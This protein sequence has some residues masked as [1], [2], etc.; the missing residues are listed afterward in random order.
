M[1][2]SCYGSASPSRVTHSGSL[3]FAFIGLPILALLGFFWLGIPDSHAWQLVLSLIAGALLILAFLWLISSVVR[4]LRNT[5][6]PCAHWLGAVLVAVWLFIKWI[7]ITAASHLDDN[8]MARSG[9]LNSKLSAS[10][11]ATLTFDRLDAW[12]HDLVLLLLWIVIPALLTPFF[13]ETVSCGLGGGVWRV[14]ARVLR[15]WQA[16]ARHHFLRTSLMYWLTGKLTGWRPSH[17]V[18]GELISLA[19]RLCLCYIADFLLIT[20]LLAIDSHLLARE[21]GPPEPRCGAN[22]GPRLSRIAQSACSPKPRPH[23]V[24][25]ATA[26]NLSRAVMRRRSAHSS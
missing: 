3:L 2:H 25:L 11:R 23:D 1:T 13:I 7:L 20:L 21:H 8:A 14:A 5:G 6:T 10:M 16:L 26:V 22:H 17:S 19:V 9:Y 4:S 12:Q 15:S 24:L 18:H